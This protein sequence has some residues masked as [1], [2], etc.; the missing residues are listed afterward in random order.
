MSKNIISTEKKKIDSKKSNYPTIKDINK[1]WEND[2]WGQEK[3]ISFTKN[4]KKIK[5][6]HDRRYAYTLFINKREYIEDILNK[7]NLL[8]IKYLRDNIA[9]NWDFGENYYGNNRSRTNKYFDKNNKYH[10]MDL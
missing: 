1:Y 10:L 5:L 2:Y 4:F 6:E 9:D 7:E 3:P 8:S